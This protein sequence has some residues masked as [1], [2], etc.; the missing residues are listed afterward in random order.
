MR[1]NGSERAKGKEKK[2][3]VITLEPKFSVGFAFSNR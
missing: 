2:D 3:S 1:R